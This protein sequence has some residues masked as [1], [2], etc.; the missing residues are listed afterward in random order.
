MHEPWAELPRAT[1]VLPCSNIQP[2]FRSLSL[3]RS[4]LQPIYHQTLSK[5]DGKKRE[6]LAGFRAKSEQSARR[7]SSTAIEHL[8]N[9]SRRRLLCAVVVNSGGQRI[10]AARDWTCGWS[11]IQ[12]GFWLSGDQN[13]SSKRNEARSLP[14][15]SSSS[16]LNLARLDSLRDESL[17]RI[18]S[19]VL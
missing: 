15:Q 18:L 8:R 6:G 5:A 4:N 10:F 9:C 7:V 3:N 17:W 2:D 16:F 11:P 19:P 13:Q 14:L 12:S 1:E